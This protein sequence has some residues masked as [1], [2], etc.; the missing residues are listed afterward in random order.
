[1]TDETKAAPRD[2]WVVVDALGRTLAHFGT[3][4]AALSHADSRDRSLK[5]F[6]DS[7]HTVNRYVLAAEVTT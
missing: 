2:V 7:P 5:S 3:E 1:M 6:N 4:A